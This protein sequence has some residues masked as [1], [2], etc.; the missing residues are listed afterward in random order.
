[1]NDP[2]PRQA[3]AFQTSLRYVYPHDA[4]DIKAHRFFR[5]TDWAR[6]HELTPPFVPSIRAED[7]ARYFED[8]EEI[9]DWSTSGEESDLEIEALVQPQQ[10]GQNDISIAQGTNAQTQI[11]A[12]IS[13]LYTAIP[14]TPSH[15]RNPMFLHAVAPAFPQCSVQSNTISYF[16]ACHPQMMMAVGHRHYPTA[17]EATPTPGTSKSIALSG[18]SKELQILAQ[19]YIASPFDGTRLRRIEREIEG[20]PLAT[21]M[22]KEALINF[23]RQFS[24]RERRRPRDRLLRDR[25]TRDTV[26]KVRKRDAFLGYTWCRRKHTRRVGLE[27]YERSLVNSGHNNAVIGLQYDSYSSLKSRRQLGVR[28]NIPLDN[29][30]DI[31]SGC[32]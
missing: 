32:L 31:Q 30:S 14:Q 15:E 20:L 1:M 24:K 19:S 10:L 22:E 2:L 28:A 27:D 21:P 3:I 25:G 23:V 13:S 12:N 18:F 4:E 29:E 9:S 11:Y 5:G 8:E 6:L 7:D 26:M 16:M 17:R